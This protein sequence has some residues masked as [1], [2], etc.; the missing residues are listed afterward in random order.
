MVSRSFGVGSLF[1]MSDWGPQFLGAKGHSPRTV[2]GHARLGQHAG[3]T[4]FATMTGV[5]DH[6]ARGRETEAEKRWKQ[7]R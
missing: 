4:R 7:H 1:L 6:V 3:F 5:G 2:A